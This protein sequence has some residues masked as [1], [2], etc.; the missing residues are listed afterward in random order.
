MVLIWLDTWYQYWADASV[1]LIKSRMETF[2]YWLTQVHSEKWL[3]KRERER[4]NTVIHY[5]PMSF[6]SHDHF[7]YNSIRPAALP[8]FVIFSSFKIWSSLIFSR[9]P[10]SFHKLSVFQYCIHLAVVHVSLLFS[11]TWSLSTR[12]IHP[13]P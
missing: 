13:S 8:F 4:D 5:V 7:C 9:G 2:W 1:A 10:V 6:I 3:L 12:T 11:F